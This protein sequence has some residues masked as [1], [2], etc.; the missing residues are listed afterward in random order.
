[1]IEN[2]GFRDS[3]VVI[4]RADFDN[5]ESKVKEIFEDFPKDFNGKKVLVKPN[6][7]G[8]FSPEK[9]A[10]THPL[11]AKAVVD[12][13]ES[14]GAF[15]VVGDNPGRVG[16]G[17]NE[18]CFS[19]SGLLD[20]VKKNYKNIS[21]NFDRYRIGGELEE[22]SISRDVLDSDYVISLAKFK[23]HQLTQITGAI[24]NTF[25]YLVGGDK[26]R[27]HRTG[28][29]PEKFAETLL[30]IFEIRKPDLTIVEG[31][32]AMEGNGPTN[33]EL[34]YGVNRLI[35]SENAL[36]LDSVLAY[37]AN[38]NP[39][40]IP[41][42][43]VAY[44]RNLGEIDLDK[45]EVEGDFEVFGFKKPH[46]YNDG[47]KSRILQRLGNTF[48]YGILFSKGAKLKV[49][50]DKCVGCGVCY[51]VCP[52][53]EKAITMELNGDG[54]KPKFNKDRCIQCYCCDELCPEGAIYKT[55]PLGRKLFDKII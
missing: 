2:S 24:K 43:K 44:K 21:H 7:I 25:G 22:V 42:Y 37:M 23:T 17:K 31:I 10:T 4:K 55:T 36:N 14:K 13:L 40:E 38:F 5:I 41:F 3:K 54:K 50:E 16:Y 18:Y 45:I 30:D 9:H 29:T 34:R 27:A 47:F 26:A 32:V 39:H 1:M 49:D 48:V 12:Y 46:T 11:L 20:V 35:A 52:A 51:E 6:I 19:K 33:G 28:T 53:P 15:V 8:A